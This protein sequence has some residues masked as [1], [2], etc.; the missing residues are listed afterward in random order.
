M[1]IDKLPDA[2]EQIDKLC[3]LTKCQKI[4]NF[5]VYD[6]SL[7]FIINWYRLKDKI[8]KEK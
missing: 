3:Q 4:R 1:K 5:F 7:W 6:I 2:F 8:R